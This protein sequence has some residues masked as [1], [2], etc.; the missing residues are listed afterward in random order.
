MRG[1]LIGTASLLAVSTIALAAA[2]KPVV[3]NMNDASGTNVGTVTFTRHGKTVDVRV[4]LMAMA[5]GEHALHVHAGGTCTPPDF[6]SAA[7]HLNPD[8]KHHGFLNPEGHHAGDFPMSVKV[9][10]DGKGSAELHSTDLSL[11]AASATSI[12]GHSV[13]IHELADDEK[14][15]PAGASG[16]RIACG[17][18][19][20]APSM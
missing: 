13:V 7:G 18:I 16:K 4:V 19:P 15:D 17:V 20:A 6:T 5:A 8:S 1:V 12:Y 10:A 9:K 14:T 3:V 2:V 11:D